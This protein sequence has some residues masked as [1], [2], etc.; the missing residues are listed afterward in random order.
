ML[1]RLGLLPDALTLTENK[2]LKEVSII[3]PHIIS[4]FN[5]LIAIV[6]FEQSQLSQPS[7]YKNFMNM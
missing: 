1:I 6:V 2:F 3:F 4:L 7:N 5:V